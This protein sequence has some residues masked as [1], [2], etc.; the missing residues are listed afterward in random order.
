MSMEIQTFQVTRFYCP[1]CCELAPMDVDVGQTLRHSCGWGGMITALFRG[2]GFCIDAPDPTP[3]PEEQEARDEG[4]LDDRTLELLERSVERTAPAEKRAAKPLAVAGKFM[5]DF[6]EIQTNIVLSR[7]ES[8]NVLDILS[9]PPKPTPALT[10]LLKASPEPALTPREPHQDSMLMLRAV[11][12]LA[13]VNREYLKKNA[14]PTVMLA[15]L[16]VKRHDS[17]ARRPIATLLHER[18]ADVDELAAW[19]LAELLERGEKATLRILWS[20][21][22][23]PVLL[24]QRQNGTCEIVDELMKGRLQ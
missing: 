12:A 17:E 4:L 9:R 21:R 15:D 1:K 2:H 8:E 7:E 19:R 3:E 24:V 22:G 14:V 16:R 18:S 5:L 10:A 11:E 6:G 20:E 23:V 13:A